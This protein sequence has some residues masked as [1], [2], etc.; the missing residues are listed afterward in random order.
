[1]QQY[2]Y[3][4]SYSKFSNRGRCYCFD[5]IS[6]EIDNRLCIARNKKRARRLA[7]QDIIKQL[8]FIIKG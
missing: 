3:K 6:Y 1:M 7:K 2:G 4:S 5:C 8:F